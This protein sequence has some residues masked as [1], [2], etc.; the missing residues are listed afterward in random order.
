MTN[1]YRYTYSGGKI[2][3]PRA[4]VNLKLG[5]KLFLETKDIGKQIEGGKNSFTYSVGLTPR[6]T[7]L[8]VKLKIFFFLKKQE[9]E[10]CINIFDLKYL[11]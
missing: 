7:E 3:D 1:F 8:R 2:A 4:S 11:E 5:G 6:H 10:K 9:A